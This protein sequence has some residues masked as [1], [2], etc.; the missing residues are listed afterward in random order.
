M[1]LEGNI[2]AF[3]PKKIE[4]KETGQ[5]RPEQLGDLNENKRE[6]KGYRY[7]IDNIS[8]GNITNL[9]TLESFFDSNPQFSSNGNLRDK[10]GKVIQVEGDYVSKAEFEELKRILPEQKKLLNELLL[11]RDKTTKERTKTE[12]APAGLQSVAKLISSNTFITPEALDAFFDPNPQFSSNGNLR[13]KS[14]KVIQAEGDYIP[15]SQVE[16]LKL[17]LPEQK[18]FLQDLALE[19]AKIPFE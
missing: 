5:K 15:R 6:V 3:Q 10:S 13:D 9:E 11:E 18:K 8:A 2:S 1:S 12:T 17:V 7:F 4:K 19:Y 14:G 16:E